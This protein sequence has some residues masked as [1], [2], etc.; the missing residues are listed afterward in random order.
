[1]IYLASLALIAVV[2]LI[3]IAYISRGRKPEAHDSLTD[4]LS[5]EPMVAV[6]L[7]QPTAAVIDPIAPVIPDDDFALFDPRIAVEHTV[8]AKAL[9]TPLRVMR[10]WIAHHPEIVVGDAELAEMRE[11]GLTYDDAALPLID[12]GQLV[13]SRI[14]KVV[15]NYWQDLG[16]VTDRDLTTF[17]TQA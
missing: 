7:E 2:G 12:V 16:L 14:G 1:M 17:D 5:G 15:P 11:Q 6:A 13:S 3:A 9:G 4:F 10:S 8:L